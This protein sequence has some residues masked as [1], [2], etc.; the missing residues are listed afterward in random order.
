[1]TKK[2]ILLGWG[3][4]LLFVGTLLFICSDG[5]FM[6]TYYKD[7]FIMKKMTADKVENIRQFK[8]ILYDNALKIISTCDRTF[9]PTRV[10]LFKERVKFNIK[11]YKQEEMYATSEM[12]YLMTG[13]IEEA[14]RRNDKKGIAIIKEAFDNYCL[15]D[16]FKI[17]DQSL[18]GIIALRLHDLTKERMYKV[19]ADKLYKFLTIEC[20]HNS[21]GITY[22]TP[23]EE[24]IV[25]GLG[26]YIPFLMEYYR[27]TGNKNAFD[28]ALFSI[29]KYFEFGVDAET[30]IPS[31]GFQISQP[32]LKLG[33]INWGRGISWFALALL[34]IPTDSLD[35][36]SLEKVQK[37]NES[38][39]SV[40]KSELQFSQFLGEKGDIDLTATIP[41]VY[42][43]VKNKIISLTE[44][45]L[46]SYAKYLRNGVF[47]FSS[48]PTH[49]L[50]SYSE[51]MGMNML[52]QGIMIYLINE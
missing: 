15:N 34:S 28:K 25:D 39:L 18:N 2:K 23:A 1:M 19:Y 13:T 14:I 29:N 3:V 26:M 11:G 44:E 35:S 17:V 24:Q 27:Y 20:F 40:Y 33:S 51:F 37:F 38:L 4:A 52:S 45:E 49:G 6:L 43:L 8:D 9:A 16:S 47:Y 21:V 7:K 32:H 50:N 31:H 10:G 42:Y 22:R 48:G 46:M 12:G 41:L 5:L 36:F 30:G